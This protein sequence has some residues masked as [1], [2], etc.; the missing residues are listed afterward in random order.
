MDPQLTLNAADIGLFQRMGKRV[1]D[2]VASLIGI[3]VL[4]P[5]LL[6]V[7]LLV[8]L[9]SKGPVIYRQNRITRD[10][11]VFTMYKFRSMRIDMTEGDT[12]RWTEEDDPRVTPIGRFI[13]KTSIDELPQLFNVLG[14]SMS[15]IGPRPERP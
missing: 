8:K 5:L 3:I 12:A 11:Q 7:A 6:L 15:L 10:E 13:R 9:T 4:S 1:F 2:F 14:G